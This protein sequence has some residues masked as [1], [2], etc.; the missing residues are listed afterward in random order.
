MTAPSLARRAVRLAALQALKVLEAT[1]DAK[2]LNSPGVW[3]VQADPKPSVLLRVA[4]SGKE[5][6]SKSTSNFTTVVLV[7]IETKLTA[8]SAELAQE[9]IEKIDALVE[10]ALLTNV[11]FVRASQQITIET[12]T[13]VK[14]DT[15]NHVAGTVMLLRCELVETFDPILDAPASLQPT[16]PLLEGVDL[17]ADLAGNFDPHG[18]YGDVL[19][20]NAVQPA[21]RSSGPDGRDEGGLQINLST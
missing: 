17:H 4:R 20:P 21:P 7:E 13:E 15:R 8:A 16:A 18:I 11:A 2:V 1:G 9:A 3:A 14:A 10:Q 6:M 5:P 19:F 12:E